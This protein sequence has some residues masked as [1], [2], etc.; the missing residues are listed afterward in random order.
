MIG[1]F[2]DDLMGFLDCREHMLNIQT[3]VSGD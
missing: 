2:F 3:V 1:Q